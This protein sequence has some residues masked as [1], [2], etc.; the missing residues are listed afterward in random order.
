MKPSQAAKEYASR[1]NDNGWG[2]QIAA[3]AFDAGVKWLAAQSQHIA[4]RMPENAEDDK[5]YWAGAAAVVKELMKL[6]D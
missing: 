2:E 6:S 3:E 1:F 4:I 5:A